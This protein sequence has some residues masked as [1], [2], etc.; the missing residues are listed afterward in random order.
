MTR[1]LVLGGGAQ[2]WRDLD[3]ALDLSEFDAVIACNDAAADYPGH[4][5]A[6]VTLH[7]EKVGVWLGRRK[8]LGLPKPDQVIGHDEASRGV[9]RLPEGLSG[10]TSYRFDGQADSGSSGLFALKVALIDLGHDRAVLCGV[11]MDE[12]SGHF[13][14]PS[15]WRGAASHQRGWKQALPTIKDRARSM[16]GWT[17]ELLGEPTTEWLAA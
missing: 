4:L 16:S 10:F 2:V 15:V 9:L 6:L 13:F 8:A 7:A 5:D 3:A 17:R 1:A 14:D 12:A 11:P